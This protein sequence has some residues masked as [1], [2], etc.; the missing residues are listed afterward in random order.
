[1]SFIKKFLGDQKNKMYRIVVQRVAK[2]EFAPT[3]ILLRQWATH[4]L[5]ASLLSAEITIRIVDKDE[6]T[7]LNSTYRHKNYATNILSFPFDRPKE[8]EMDIPLIGDLV[9]C[10]A[11]VNEEAKAQNK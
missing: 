7:H 8:I 9:I 10:S 3:N 6:I 4:A 2:K 5:Q 1:M 11:V